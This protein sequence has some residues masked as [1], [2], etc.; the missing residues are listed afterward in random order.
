MLS[1]VADSLYWMSRYLERAEHTARLLGVNLTQMLDQTPQ[2]T[3]QRWKRLLMSLRTNSLKIDPIDAYAITNELTFDASNSASIAA[4]IASARV[5]AR[6]V[7]EQISTEMWEQLNRLYLQVKRT[8]MDEIW[9]SEPYEFF[10]SVKDRMHQ[11]Q[12]VT[13]ATLSHGEGWQFVQLG[14]FIE[15]ACLTADVLDVHFIAYLEA[16]ASSTTLIDYTDWVALLKSCTSF[17]SY[18]KVYTANIQPSSI[19]EF[20]LLNAESPRSVRFAAD[21][22]QVALQAIARD[23]GTRHAGR[24]ER[25]AGRLRSSLSYGQV[26]EIMADSMHAYLET[27]QSQCAQIH[28]A[29]RETYVAY[30]VDAALAS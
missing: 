24:A 18:C 14:R 22:I 26:D 4:C 10:Q 17:E 19:A 30:P 29:I 23:T 21:M 7:R 1:R 28:T 5:N 20:M 16:Q 11:F 3:E 15:R 27:I 25:L 9:Y 6:Q 8:S 13:D 12:G 2:S